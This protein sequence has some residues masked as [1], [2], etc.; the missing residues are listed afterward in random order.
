M[1]K[2]LKNKTQLRLEELRKEKENISKEL[3]QWEKKEQQ[4]QEFSQVLY[5]TR[6]FTYEYFEDN[7][8]KTL[9]KIKQQSLENKDGI[10]FCLLEYEIK[11]KAEFEVYYQGLDLFEEKIKR[12]IEYET[13][14][15]VNKL[16]NIN[17]EIE[18]L[19]KSTIQRELK[20]QAKEAL[21]TNHA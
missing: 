1:T 2:E 15:I 20:K 13:R 6:R 19:E 7:I 11:D 10:D 17:S 3:T 12:D 9:A 21:L 5:K 16:W 14:Q 18:K 4:A 8:K